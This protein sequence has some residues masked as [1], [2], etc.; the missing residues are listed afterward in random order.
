[1]SLTTALFTGLTGMGTHTKALDVIGNNITNVNTIGFKGSRAIF[2]SQL[3][4]N[5]TLGTGPTSETGGI[6]PVQIG[7]GVQFAGTQRNLTNGSIQPT[8][9]CR[10]TCCSSS[11]LA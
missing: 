10:S 7:F 8:L 4:N 2:E 6:N 11:I 9:S 5:L 3:S 1:M